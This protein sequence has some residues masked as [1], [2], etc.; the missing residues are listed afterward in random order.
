MWANLTVSKISVL[1]ARIVLSLFMLGAFV[2]PAQA[3]SDDP[4][5][6]ID[7]HKRQTADERLTAYGDDLLGD[8]IDRHIGSLVFEHTDVSIPGNSGL[9]VAVRRSLSSGY[10]YDEGVNVEFGDWEIGIPKIS[11]IALQSHG[12]TG[13]RCSAAWEVSLPDASFATQSFWV[14]MSHKQY[15]N[16]VNMSIPGQGSQ[17]ILKTDVTNSPY[18]STAKNVSVNEWYFTC[19]TASDGGEGFV[20]HAPNGDKYEFNRVVIRDYKRMGFAKEGPSTKSRIKVALM[21]TKVTDVHGNWVKYTYDSSDR[22]TRIHS[23]D[24]RS[25]S[26]GY[27]GTLIS[28]VTA[29]GRTWNYTYR[30][31]NH[32]KLEWDPNTVV[33][34]FQPFESKV[35]DKVTLPDGNFWEFDLD[36]MQAEPSPPSRECQR[37]EYTVSL[38]HPHGVTGTFEIK[39]LQHRQAWKYFTTVSPNCIISSTNEPPPSNG[40]LDGSLVKN[41]Q[42]PFEVLTTRAMSVTQKTLSSPSIPTAT[43]TFDY[44]QDDPCSGLPVNACL[45]W[46]PYLSG[47]GSGG[48]TGGGGGDGPGPTDPNCGNDP[49]CVGAFRTGGGSS[50]P[51][52]N[53]QG[54]SQSGG[55]LTQV[56]TSTAT[57]VSS[58]PTCQYCFGVYYGIVDYVENTPSFTYI[59]TTA[60]AHYSDLA[61]PGHD[62]MDFT[63][64]TK[65]TQPDGTVITH[66]H[67]WTYEEG[68]GG[69]ELKQVT[70]KGTTTL[71]EVDYSYAQH[72]C[73]GTTAVFPG[74]YNQSGHCPTHTV[75]TVTKRDGDTYT[76]EAEFKMDPADIAYSYGNP[77]KTRVFSNRHRSTTPRETVTT[78]ENKSAYWV[79]ALPKIV[80]INGRL[81]TENI[82]DPKGLKTEEKRYDQ[83]Y[84]KFGYYANGLVNWFE[85]ANGRRTQAKL[86]KRGT[87]QQIVR[88]DN[89]SVHQYVDDNGWMTSSKD[90]L[91]RTTSYTRDNMGRLK[92][93]DPPG[94]WAHTD[95]SYTFNGDGAVQT[96]TKGNART[97]VT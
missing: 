97:V 70:T 39:D 29:N 23:N 17:A 30:D 82:Y 57:S 27:S 67:L 24:G 95:M 25:I 11:V 16:G 72:G 32:L 93:Y 37:W 19:M 31:S 63:N 21:A 80:T 52:G 85:D 59:K 86:W 8:S 43:W 10:K 71:N 18:P 20:G 14:E 9:E 65:V 54:G 66:Y 69:K 47:G 48:G 49:D 74:A 50:N 2:L 28:T 42:D 78:Y 60:P 89:K 96:I 83:P 41:E 7:W 34:P 84:A 22:L 91:A 12:W 64:W 45:E 35:L 4:I 51:R 44:E 6:I 55:Q 3:Q 81:T 62:P 94:S 26:L 61:Y 88:A 75:K 58:G 33:T 13:Q 53:P 77:T 87:P 40:G 79:M 1:F 46:T 5:P 76:S 38:K 73:N 15:S 68:F 56:R 36:N 92:K 90:A